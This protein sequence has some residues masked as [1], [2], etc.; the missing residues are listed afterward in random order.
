MVVYLSVVDLEA[1][2]GTWHANP[3]IG[4]A[5][6]IRATQSFPTKAGHGGLQISPEPS[7]GPGVGAAFLRAPILPLVPKVIDLDVL[8]GAQPRSGP[9]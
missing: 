8:A 7:L 9:G 1:F 2:R 3:D 6:I 5:P 4:P